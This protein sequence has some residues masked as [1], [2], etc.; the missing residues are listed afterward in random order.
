MYITF[1]LCLIAALLIHHMSD[2]LPISL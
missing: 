1:L 2:Q